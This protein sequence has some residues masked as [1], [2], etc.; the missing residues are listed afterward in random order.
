VSDGEL[1]HLVEARR[2][3]GAP[4]M[5]RIRELAP[6][7]D[8]PRL[9]VVEIPYPITGLSRMPDA[10]AYR[11]LAV[12]E[13]QWLMPACAA[14]ACTFV[15]AKI[16]DGS[17]FYYLYGAGPPLALIE[18]LSPFDGGLGFFD[19]HDPAWA[20]YA[21]LRELLAQA[22]AVPRPPP[23]D[24]PTRTIPRLARAETTVI[25]KPAPKKKPKP[26]RKMAAQQ[27]ARRAARYSRNRP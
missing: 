6:R 8:Q 20:E 27:R 15:A 22:R 25:T 1:W 13:E 7:T 3:D 5:F 10:A 4:T 12:F 19:E 2:E 9:F 14:L 16:D 11:R 23:A 24:L 17:C 18:K 21:A 26:A